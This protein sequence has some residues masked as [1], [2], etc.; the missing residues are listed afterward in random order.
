MENQYGFVKIKAQQIVLGKKVRKLLANN[1]IHSVAAP[2]FEAPGVIVSY[3]N[4]SAIQNGKK[5]ANQGLQIAAGVT[6]KCDEREDFQS[7]RLGLFG[8]DKL[9]NIEQT[10]A[11]L[12][13]ALEKVFA[14]N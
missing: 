3:T 11:N 2:G 10:L 6:L 1:G 13:Q 7:F 8:F 5:F 4:D 14:P 9:H 12:E